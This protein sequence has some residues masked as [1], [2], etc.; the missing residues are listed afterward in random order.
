MD[1]K[2]YKNVILFIVGFCL[3]ITIE[4]LFR[5]YSYPLMGVCAGLVVVVLDKINDHISWD[6]DSPIQTPMVVQAAEPQFGSS[7]LTYTVDDY[8]YV[9]IPE[10]INV[11]T[12]SEIYAMETNISPEKSIYVRIEGL[13]SNGAIQLHNDN[14]SSKSINVFFVDKT[15]NRCNSGNNI[16]A[17]FGS[18]Q[19]GQI[20]TFNTEVDA[21]PHSASAGLYSGQVYFSMICE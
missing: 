12:E 19:D 17:Q 16:I 13:D 21:D 4:V 20:A 15:G 11:G 6:I 7:T 1:K 10:T 14:D 18:S 2:L 3:Y 5:G 9:Q 8:F